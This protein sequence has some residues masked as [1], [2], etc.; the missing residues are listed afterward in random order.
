MFRVIGLSIQEKRFNIDFQDSN[1]GDHLGY[2]IRNI[3]VTF[4]EQAKSILPMKFQVNWPFGSEEKFQNRFS[5][6]LL[7][8]Q[9]WISNQNDFSYFFI[10][11]SP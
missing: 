7:G 11:K 6:W 2:Q 8:T 5:T 4:D 1:H 3:L 10:Y 9:S